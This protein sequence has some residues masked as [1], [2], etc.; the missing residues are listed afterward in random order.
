MVALK[1]PEKVITPKIDKLRSEI[2]ESPHR[3]STYKQMARV[4]IGMD[5]E[6]LAGRV[7]RTGLTEIPDDK[8]L[9]ENLARA[10][11]A[12]GFLGAAATT[13]RKVKRLFPESFL[14]YEKL[15]RYYVR[16]GKPQSAVNMYR[17][18]DEDDPLKEKSLERTVFV[19]KEAMDV[20]GTV[21]AL[22]KLIKNYGVTY[23]R[24]RDLGRFHFKADHYKE[25]S[26]WLEKAF[27]MEE[28]D[29]DL[30]LNLALAYA[31]QQRYRL[32]EKHI[33]HILADRPNSFAAL[34][35]LCEFTIEEGDIERAE[36]ILAR[37]EKAYSNNSRANLARGEIYL[38]KGNPATAEKA[39]RSGIRGT[40]YFYRWELERGYR[41]LGDTL[42]YQG[43]GEEAD[44][45]RLLADSLSGAPDAYQAFIKLAEDKLEEQEMI[46]ASRIFSE[47][48]RMFPNNARI[49]TGEAKVEIFKGY[50]LKAIDMLNRVI[51]KTPEKF[52]QDKSRGYRVLA[53]AYKNL[54][55]WEGARNS[56]AQAETIESSL[57]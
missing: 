15:E 9:L 13:W 28:G 46:L 52:I 39:L 47:L 36:K 17:R 20:S 45:C 5:K 21:R 12:G 2:T 44:F 25:A 8:G 14:S 53:H 32:A 49:V 38:L 34:I 18:V 37:L 29:N 54:G 23:R 4:L 11:Q 51:E 31:R 24:A 6:R 35:N 41:L 33:N 30:R 56:L 1:L 48:S 40:A 19:C 42:E 50:P 10:Q 16:S 43:N 27:S 55:D 26:R 57:G 3:A 7:L 22:K